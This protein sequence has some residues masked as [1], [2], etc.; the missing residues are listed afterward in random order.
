MQHISVTYKQ[1]VCGEI[2]EQVE[3]S[4][5]HGRLAVGFYRT[6]Y[7]EYRVETFDLDL[8]TTFQ[9]APGLF[10]FADAMMKAM[11]FLGMT[12]EKM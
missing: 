4:L 1:T 3:M 5:N 7:D 2:T 10:T 8:D 9:R 12:P 11:I 6:G